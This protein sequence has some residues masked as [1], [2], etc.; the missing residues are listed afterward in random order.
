MGVG[1]GVGV[2]VR[3]GVGMSVGV[4]KGVGVGFDDCGE[5][6]EFDVEDGVGVATGVPLILVTII[7]DPMEMFCDVALFPVGVGTIIA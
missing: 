7:L 6:P 5:D 1:V 2:G 3:V 4:G